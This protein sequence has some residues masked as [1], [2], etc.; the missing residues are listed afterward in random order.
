MKTLK[1]EWKHLDV[2]GDTCNRC[3][4][5]G[6]NLVQEIKRLNR[7]RGTSSTNKKF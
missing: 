4:E 6:E 2:A 7:Y 5:T 3:Y 1:I